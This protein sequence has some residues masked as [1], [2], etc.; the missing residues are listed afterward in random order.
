MKSK[1]VKGLNMRKI[2]RGVFE[3]NSS[4]THSISIFE[5]KRVKESDIPRDSVLEVFGVSGWD[6]DIFDEVGKLNYIVCMLAS[7]EDDLKY[8]NKLCYNE[9]DFCEFI[10]QPKFKWLSELVKFE[11]NTELKYSKYSKSFP[12]YSTTNDDNDSI[13]DILSD[14]HKYNLNNEEEFKQRCKEIIFDE[15][16][17]ISDEDEE[18]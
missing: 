5:K 7:I 2:R 13:W 4:S 8:G 6:R 12:Y 1:S 18:Y 15:D 3:T 14:D 17:C 16:V 10:S 9:N 11:R